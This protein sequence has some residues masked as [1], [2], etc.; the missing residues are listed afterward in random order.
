MIL[1]DGWQEMVCIY[2]EIFEKA[3]SS[4]INIKDW[5]RTG[6]NVDTDHEYSHP[7]HLSLR[8]SKTRLFAMN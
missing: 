6:S 3:D 1:T 4:Q 5:I 2:E 8:S 7:D